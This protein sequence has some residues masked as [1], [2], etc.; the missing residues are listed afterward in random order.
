MFDAGQE[1]NF[2]YT[3]ISGTNVLFDSYLKI[4][5][6]HYTYEEIAPTVGTNY[7]RING[8]DFPL[9]MPLS[10]EDRVRSVVDLVRAAGVLVTFISKR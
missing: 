7:P 4:E 3:T 9:R 6:T 5:S 10:L 2:S 1:E 8:Y